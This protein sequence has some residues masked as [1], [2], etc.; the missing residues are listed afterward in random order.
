MVRTYVGDGMV[1]VCGSVHGAQR[2]A[3][4]DAAASGRAAAATPRARERRREAEVS[5][6][7]RG[8]EA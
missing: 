7:S 8:R 6:G 4:R 2:R 5:V 3:D 1:R